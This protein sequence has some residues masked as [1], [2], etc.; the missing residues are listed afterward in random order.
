MVSL[1]SQ[2]KLFLQLMWMKVVSS[3][4]MPMIE[5]DWRLLICRILG[6]FYFLNGSPKR[7]KVSSLYPR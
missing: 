3:V 5:T 2:V 6:V 7:G 4:L 1:G